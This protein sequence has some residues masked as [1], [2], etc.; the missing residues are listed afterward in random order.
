[1]SGEGS[2][3]PLA[4][5][6][7]SPGR[8]EVE[9]RGRRASGRSRISGVSCRSASWALHQRASGVDRCGRR[10]CGGN[11]CRVAAGRRDTGPAPGD[12]LRDRR[13]V[14]R[15][16]HL[17]RRVARQPSARLRRVDGGAVEGVG[18]LA[19]RHRGAYARGHRGRELPVLGSGWPCNRVLRRGKTETGRSGR[20]RAAG[21]GRRLE[22]TRRNVERGWRD[23]VHAGQQFGGAR[24]RDYADIRRGRHARGGDA[25]GGRRRQPPV[26]AVSSRWTPVHV[27]QHAW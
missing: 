12:A 20:R 22:R 2:G 24:Q 9:R 25:P 17:A 3:R 1:M 18:A 21:A 15:Q 23:S 5:G 11:S 14:N 4:D 13:A 8:T 27:L 7:G 16:S 19:R 6:A 26:A 10:A